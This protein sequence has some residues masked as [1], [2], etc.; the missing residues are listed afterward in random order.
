[1]TKSLTIA[2][3]HDIEVRLHPTIALVFLWVVI[4]WRR[5]GAGHGVVAV[6]FTWPWVL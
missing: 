5:L 1:M 6:V 2:R 4:D 3:I